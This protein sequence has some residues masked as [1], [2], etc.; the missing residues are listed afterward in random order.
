MGYYFARAIHKDR[1]VPVGIIE[2][3]HGG[4][5][6]LSWMSEAA[7][8]S[9]PRF[10]ALAADRVAVRDEMLANLPVVEDAV[11][12]WAADARRNAAIMRPVMAFPVDASPIR[13]F[14][15]AFVQ[16]P[17]NRRGSMFY[18]AMI[19]SIIGYGVRGVL[20]NQGEADGGRA[21][22]YDDLM[23]AMIADWRK[24]WGLELPFYY[25][26]MPAKK[27]SGDLLSMWDAQTRAC[28]D[29]QQRHD[30]M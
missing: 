4:S 24:S 18:N 9:S 25:V 2:A 15:S 19:Y 11:R 27:S 7:L 6:I 20:W 10:T 23:A 12:R 16:N 14:Y 1:H 22:I 13:P 28:Q 30:R 29:S 5:T 26:Q 3:N 17:L 21:D 8:A